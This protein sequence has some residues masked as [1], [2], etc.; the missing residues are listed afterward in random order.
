MFNM[1]KGAVKG[2]SKAIGKKKGKLKEMLSKYLGGSS[3]YKRN[4]SE[5]DRFK[6]DQSDKK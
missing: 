1:L 4:K 2:A 6:K 5:V 3:E